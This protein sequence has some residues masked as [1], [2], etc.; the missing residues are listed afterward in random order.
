MQ[1][2]QQL[3]R[4]VGIKSVAVLGMTFKADSDDTRNSLS[5]KLLHQLERLGYQPVCVDPNV[6]GLPPL[7][8]IRG[9]DAV[10]LMTPHRE[11]KDLEFIRQ[12][13]G[14]ESCVYVDIWGFWDQ[15]RHTSSNGLFLDSQ[16]S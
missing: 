14:N 8:K 2:V 7:S 11:F 12:A 1:I 9:S 6:P 13:V 5:F 16:V 3:E 10:I 4:H 15:M